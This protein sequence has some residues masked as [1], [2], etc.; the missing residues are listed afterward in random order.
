MARLSQSDLEHAVGGAARL[1]QLLDPGKTGVADPT[2]VNEVLAETDSEVDSMI[3]TV[4]NLADPSVATAPPLLRRSRAIASYIAH[5]KG[6]DG[7]GVPSETRRAYDDALGWLDKVANRRASLGAA[8]RPA[9][10]QM[11]QQVVKTTNDPFS[12]TKSPRRAFDGWS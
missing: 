6:T 4:V 12:S 3:G 10:S 9:T 7:Q 11:V 1:V 8:A 5:Y 2:L